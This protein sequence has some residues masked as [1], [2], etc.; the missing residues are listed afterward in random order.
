MLRDSPITAPLAT[1]LLSEQ[2]AA[3][4][5]GLSSRYLQE[6]RY[7]GGGPTYIRISHRTVR[8]D[9]AA[10]AAWLMERSYTATCQE[11]AGSNSESDEESL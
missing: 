9:P 3:E 10:L 4:Y 6:R 7:R 1:A 2:Q 11:P 5:L 8:Y